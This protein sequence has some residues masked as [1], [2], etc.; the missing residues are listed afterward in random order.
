[1]PYYNN[2]RVG[3]AMDAD[4]IYYNLTI[5]NNF[6]SILPPQVYPT[7]SPTGVF[8]IGD[9][10][11]YL[12]IYYVLQITVSP[13]PAP[14]DL[15]GTLFW[16]SVTYDPAYP[17]WTSGTYAV[18]DYVNDGFG[19]SFQLFSLSPDPSNILSGAYWTVTAA[20]TNTPLDTTKS[21]IPIEFNQ[22]RAQPYL[23]NP[24]EYFLSVQRFTLDNTATPVFIAQ[25]SIGSSNVNQTIYSISVSISNSGSAYVTQTLPIT[26]I[27]QDTTLTAPTGPITQADVTNPYYYCYSYDWFVYCINQTINSFTG[28]TNRPIL[29]FDPVTQLFTIQARPAEY[30]TNIQ[31]TIL[32]AG[33]QKA[34]LFMN[35]ALFNLFSS[36]NFIYYGG[37]GGGIALAPAGV[38]LDYQILFPINGLLTNATPY[39]NNVV[40]NT[41]NNG[42]LTAVNAIHMVQEYSTLA[43]WSPIKSIVFRGS[44]LNVVSEM[45]ATPVIF[46]NGVNINAGKQ[47]TD[48]LPILI[49]YSVPLKTGTEYKPSIYFEPTAEYRLADL[50][51]DIPV[52]GLQFNVFWKDTFG[53]LNPFLLSFGSKATMKLLFRK[54]SF[55][56]DKL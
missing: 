8:N 6:D 5:S 23:I 53:N 4:H 15:D 49:E 35:T 47:N 45:V 36:F 18:G 24:S 28:L 20:P 2:V 56:S 29:S 51:S 50:Y 13:Q 19:N 40:T 14:F 42:T 17:T 10:V 52:Y 44:L 46:Q 31:G 1:M 39:I 34:F 9:T 38:G 32:A 3:G 12:G 30:R 7:W 27:P 55:N 41:W 21:S 25:P 54:K 43:L 48:I 33:T 22:N 37:L 11:V 26:W 16:N